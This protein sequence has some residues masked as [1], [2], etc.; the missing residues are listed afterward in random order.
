MSI[1]RQEMVGREME[2][3]VRGETLVLLAKR[4]KHTIKKG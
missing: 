4:Q 3:K 2:M 1:L